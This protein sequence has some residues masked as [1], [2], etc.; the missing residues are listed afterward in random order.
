VRKGGARTEKPGRAE[1]LSAGGLH[2]P[3]KAT[4]KILELH[5]LRGVEVPRL[6]PRFFSAPPVGLL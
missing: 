1:E 5:E 2:A 3:A 6:V 4:K